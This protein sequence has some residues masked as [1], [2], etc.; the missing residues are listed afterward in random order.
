MEIKDFVK[1]TLT[2]LSEA[3]D[4]LNKESDKRV[5]LTN[6]VLRTKQMG[7]DGL[8]DFD[9]AVEAKTAEKTGK[10]AGVRISVVE[11]RFGKDKE[12]VSS[13]VS[14]VKFTVEANF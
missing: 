12:L 4:E 6:T 13:S 7:H 10:G 3:L 14:R 1:T 2:Q 8:I 9:L 11:A 5:Q